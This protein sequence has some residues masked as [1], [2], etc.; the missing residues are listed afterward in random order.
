MIRELKIGWI[1]WIDSVWLRS[2]KI[3][4]I[5]TKYS[6]HELDLEAC[7]ESNQKARIDKYEN[8]SFL[9]FHFPKYNSKRKIYE[10][11]EFKIFLWKDYLITL[12][13]STGSHINKIF[14]YY[15]DIK[16]ATKKKDIKVTSWYILYEITQAMLEKMFRV[17][18]KINLDIKKIEWQIFDWDNN[19]S[20]VRDI[21]I[22]K[23][24]IIL[25]KHMFRPQ[26]NV[27]KQLENVVNDLYSG[28]IEVYF[29]DLED[30]LEQVVNEID[31]LQESIES[32]EDA[33]KSMLDIKTNFVI[34]VL[35]V[36]SAFML[37]LTFITSFYW[38]NVD[39]PYTES[40]K[41]IVFLL[42][43]SLF[44]M[45]LIYVWLRKNWKF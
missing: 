25:L 13:D 36:F 26:V 12:R 19:S 45:V 38:M 6:I 8:Y 22:K 7:I 17:T 23:R 29:E 32:I 44:I 16:V 41:F 27:L 10:L 35:T 18:K 15:N 40:I 4:D 24:N 30:K 31:T 9:I 42:F 11:N 34:K 20:L 5:L 43:I 1:K 33:F 2:D 28:K 14:K 37:P 39:L 21:M 3:E